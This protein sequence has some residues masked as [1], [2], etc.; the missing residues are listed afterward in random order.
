MRQPSP[1]SSAVV[2]TIKLAVQLTWRSP[3]SSMCHHKLPFSAALSLKF[4]S[5]KVHVC[6]KNILHMYFVLDRKSFN[7]AN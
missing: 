2:Y 4:I 1:S 6:R 5:R 7:L 3:S